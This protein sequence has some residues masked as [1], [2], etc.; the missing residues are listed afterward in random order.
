MRRGLRLFVI[1][2]SF[3]LTGIDLKCIGADAI[4]VLEGTTVL[5]KQFSHSF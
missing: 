4:V 5:V 2:A 3:A 1:D